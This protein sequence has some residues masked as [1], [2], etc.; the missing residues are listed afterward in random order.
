MR[1]TN[2]QEKY[3]RVPQEFLD[4]FP[5]MDIKKANK[6]YDTYLKSLRQLLLKRL[7]Y[8]TTNY[9]HISLN[10]LW[11]N[12]FYYKNKTYYIWQEFKDTRPFLYVI[13][14]KKG[15]GRKKGSAFEQNSEVYIMNQKLIDL[16]IDTADANELVSLYYGDLTPETIDQLEIVPIDMDSLDSYIQS[17]T[18]EI[19]KSEKNSKHEAMLYRNLRQ[20][21]YVKIISDVFYSV[22]NQNV[23]PQIPKPSPYGRVY[24]RG[25]NLQNMTKEVRRA[26][27]GKHYVYDL[28][29][30]IYAIK[31]MLAKKVLKANDIDDYGHFT[32]TKEYLDWKA[33]LRK[34]L[35]KHIT[36]Y[37]D[38]E[39]LVKDAIT[40][41]G[42]GARIGGGSWLVD[43][44]WHTTSIEDIIMN[45][46]DRE[47]FM[48]DPWIKKFVKEQHVMTTI[49][50]DD[51]IKDSNFIELVKDVP[52]MVKNNKIRKSQVMSYLFQ[53]TE[54]M[55]IDLITE[56]IPVITKVHDSFITKDKLTNEQLTT[57]RYELNQ[58]EPLM[59]IGSE[60]YMAWLNPDDIDDESDI[61]AAFSKLTGVNHIRPKVILKHKQTKNTPEGYY[62]SET[63][64]GQ[65]DYDPDS[66]HIAKELTGEEL[67]NHY[68]IVGYKPEI[69]PDHIKKIM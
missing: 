38:G 65:K 25:I 24:Y 31:L 42:F 45:K 2:Y 59:T 12:R 43:G 18:K 50:A 63:D 9:I 8:T 28:N 20:A 56:N 37:S 23:L 47:N 16:L 3:L 29:A 13:E 40:A 61:D 44:E 35:A 51:F 1:T 62:D 22:Y 55:I 30:A 6:H 39:K 66:D 64:Y 53:H 46:T 33:P 32:Y 21:K 15:N 7:P 60:E 10:D 69:L 52:N 19:E 34:Q 14:H 26:C 54:K 48:N 27:L 4:K 17:T 68:R 11:Y 41:I 49:I 36:A 5:E 67:K 57:I 58:L